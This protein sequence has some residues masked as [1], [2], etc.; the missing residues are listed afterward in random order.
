MRTLKLNKILE[1][2][3]VPQILIANDALGTYYLCVLYDYINNSGYQ[4]IAVQIPLTKLTS[5]VNGNE[6]LRALFENP[7]FEDSVY[8][9]SVNN[10]VLSASLLNKDDIR[11]DMLPLEGYYFEADTQ[12]EDDIIIAE[13]LACNHPIVRLGF[14]DQEN[15]HT[16]DASCLSQAIAHYQSLVSNCYKK[17]NGKELLNQA[18][19]RVTTFQAASFDIH[20]QVNA[21]LNLFGS[22]NMDGTF[23][24]LDN[25]FNADN[26]EAFKEAIM[27]LRGHTVNSYKN[28]LEVLIEHRLNVKYKWVASIADNEVVSGRMSL[29]RIEYVYDLL[30][31]SQE[32]Q[33]ENVS[34]EGIF[35]ASSV[36]NGKWTF[37]PNEGR[38]NIN[39]I[40]ED[41][42]ILSGVVIEQQMYKIYCK[43]IQE[44]NIVSLKISKKLVLYRL[45]VINSQKT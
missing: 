12:E 27:N 5:F 37:K 19:L 17:I 18:E 33:T 44:Q 41:F 7:I 40:S 34:F 45:D 10:E 42:D 43:E 28:F 25:L 6:D 30:Q 21:D 39:G 15:S 31:K 4:Y 11:D 38:R 8:N 13:T 14:E 2:Y 26:E 23:R 29:P 32:L 20:F 35:L 1:Y 24:Q 9:V 3:D 22:S 16:I 36:E